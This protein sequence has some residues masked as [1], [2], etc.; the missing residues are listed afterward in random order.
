LWR[1]DLTCV[2][3][4]II[5]YFSIVFVKIK[6]ILVSSS[7]TTHGEIKLITIAH[8]RPAPEHSTNIWCWRTADT[9]DLCD[10]VKK[11]KQYESKSNVGF[12][13]LSLLAQKSSSK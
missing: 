7:G 10:F 5:Y 3:K 13:L 9:P 11:R 2:I 8:R 1:E 12:S 4:T 6:G